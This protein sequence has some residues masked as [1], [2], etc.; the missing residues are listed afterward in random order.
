MLALLLAGGWI[1]LRPAVVQALLEEP[2]C[3]LL[4]FPAVVAAVDALLQDLVRAPLA[5][6]IAGRPGRGLAWNRPAVVQA[7]LEGVVTELAALLRRMS[8]VEAAVDHTLG[9][10]MAA[11]AAG[12][13][14]MAFLDTAALEMFRPALALVRI[15]IHTSFLGACPGNS[16]RRLDLAGHTLPL[17][18]ARLDRRA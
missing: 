15:S 5:H 12:R 4:A 8:E 16:L 3:V 2:M 1:V 17:L 18:V 10:F 11:I 6:L 9:H 13:R 7:A 14:H